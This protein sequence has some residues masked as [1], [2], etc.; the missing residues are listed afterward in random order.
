MSWYDPLCSML[1]HQDLDWKNWKERKW[2]VLKTMSTR[3]W[4]L[5]FWRMFRLFCE[6]ESRK[7]DQPRQLSSIYN[8]MWSAPFCQI[9]LLIKGPVIECKKN[10]YNILMR[11]A[12]W[13]SLEA[14]WAYSRHL[15]HQEERERN[16]GLIG[17]MKKLT[18]EG[19]M[20]VN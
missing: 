11:I 4:K 15:K 12:C 19:I 13:F 8:S 2:P 5:S 18:S 20:V 7:K 9:I 16:P 6:I 14:R 17:F 3:F 1:E 10:L